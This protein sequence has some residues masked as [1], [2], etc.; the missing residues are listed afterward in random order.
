MPKGPSLLATGFVCFGGGH[1]IP[2]KLIVCPGSSF[3]RSLGLGGDWRGR[4][5][6]GRG[7]S[8][9]GDG[10]DRGSSLTVPKSRNSF[11]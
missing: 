7:S 2:Q 9:G 10:V 6:K 11:I 8:P 5:C 1:L 4:G 3:L